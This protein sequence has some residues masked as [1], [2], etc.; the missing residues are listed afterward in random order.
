L[1][2][3]MRRVALFTSGVAELTRH[4]AERMVRQ[5]VREGEV[6]KD[7]ASQMVR[8]LLEISEHSRRELAALVRAEIRNQVEALGLASKRDVQR[9]ARRLDR[10]E[11]SS[12]KTTGSD[13]LGDRG[14]TAR[15]K[16]A[17]RKKTPRGRLTE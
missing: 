14:K 12:K 2:E 3:E 13:R 1:L 15:K 8:S 5:W 4:R 10:L 16:T 11:A 9:L 17:A 6:R 7:Q